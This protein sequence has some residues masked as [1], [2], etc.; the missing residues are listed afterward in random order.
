MPRFFLPALFLV[1]ALAPAQAGKSPPKIFLAVYVQTTGDG[2]AD[3]QSRPMQIPPNG[4]TI[5][6]RS[7]PEIT[8][9]NLVDAQQDS[10]G[11]LHLHF[12]HIGQVNL[13]AVTGQN[14]GRI[15]VLTLNGYILFAP[16][17]D[18]QITDGEL[19]V[20]HALDP[21]VLKLLQD[22]AAQNIR[23]ANRH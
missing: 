23:E 11:N 19:I 21:R 2:Q 8:E 6:I 12:D 13:S 5:M 15:L 9:R 3:T 16:L 17:I 20:P 4:E 1:L 7:L 18:E 14:Q 10:A 22:T